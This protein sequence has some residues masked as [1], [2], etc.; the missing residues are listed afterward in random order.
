MG[1][2][3]GAAVAGAAVA[4]AAVAGAAVA[5]A[6]VAGAGVVA[7]AQ[8]DRPNTN[9]M[10]NPTNNVIFFDIST[11]LFLDFFNQPSYDGLT[12][13]PEKFYYLVC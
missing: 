8:A 6:A 7:G 12:N 5:G 9:A 1:S 13:Q 2:T 3:V 11:L 4:G 10:N